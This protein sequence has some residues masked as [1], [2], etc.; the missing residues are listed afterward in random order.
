MVADSVAIVRG[1]AKILWLVTMWVEDPRLALRFPSW[2]AAVAFLMRV[3]IQGL[4]PVEL[5]E[6]S[7]A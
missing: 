1:R 5:K 4:V 7:E 2:R 6:G 3:Q